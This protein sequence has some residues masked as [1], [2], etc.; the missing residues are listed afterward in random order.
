MRDLNNK[1]KETPIINFESSTS[2]IDNLLLNNLTSVLHSPI[3]NL[4]E[5]NI[6]IK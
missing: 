1:E 2:I 6:N 3:I 5:S 4:H